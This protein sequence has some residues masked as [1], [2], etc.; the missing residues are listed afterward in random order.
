MKL[1]TSSCSVRCKRNLRFAREAKQY[2]QLY[3][4]LFHP[5]PFK[6]FA[7]VENFLPTGIS[8]PTYTLLGQEVVRLPFI[9][10]TSLGHE[11]LHQWFG[12]QVYGSVF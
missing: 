10:E 5:F 4:T 12:N 8:M 11:V 2:I 7:I 6:R 3:E 1:E 9:V